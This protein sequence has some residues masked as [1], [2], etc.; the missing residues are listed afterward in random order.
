M[1]G[2]APSH[3]DPFDL[4]LDRFD[5]FSPMPTQGEGFRRRQRTSEDD[6]ISRVSD[7]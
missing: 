1:Y 4:S 5:T 7:G 6:E 2:T 3:D